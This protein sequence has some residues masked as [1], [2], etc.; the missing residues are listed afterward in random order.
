MLAQSSALISKGQFGSESVS[1]LL[2]N[3][4][5]YSA[6]KVFISSFLLG[7]SNGFSSVY[8]KSSAA[9]VAS[10]ATSALTFFTVY[11]VTAPTDVPFTFTSFTVYPSSGV[12]VNVASVP[13]ST[14]SGPSILPF[15]PAV[16]VT[17]YSTVCTSFATISN[18]SRRGA[19][20]APPTIVRRPSPGSST[21]ISNVC[22][23]YAPCAASVAP[24]VTLPALIF[25]SA[26]DHSILFFASPL[27]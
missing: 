17:L 27:M 15:S 6:S 26:S 13:A 7:N 3:S 20:F 24:A 2:I 25:P 8:L 10:I 22:S 18:L 14:L 23:W 19:L 11:V 1:L 5:A 21:S 12:I 9:N 16:F 4:V